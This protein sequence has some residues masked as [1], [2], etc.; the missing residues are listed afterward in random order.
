MSQW[1]DP[2]SVVVLSGDEDFLRVRE[3]R[4]AVAVSDETGRSV[5]YVEG[6]NRD[7]ISRVLSS[8]GVFFQ[9]DVLLVVERPEPVD[10][11]LLIRHHE[12]E[13]SS[14]CV[15]L[16][17]EGKIKPGTGLAEV[18]DA[19]P[20]RLVA[21]FDKP[22]PWEVVDRAVDFCVEQARRRE[23]KLPE[24][25]ARAIVQNVGADL[26]ML[27]FE[28]EKIARY[29]GSEGIAEATPGHVK[30]VLGAFSQLGPKPVVEALERRDSKQ[31]GNALAN[32]R[33]THAGNLS[34][35][36]LRACA[37][38][39][40]AA[41]GWLHVAA[42]LGEGADAEE[43]ASRVSAHPFVVRRNLL[44]VARRWGEGRLVSLL[45][46]IARVERSV[47]S[48]HVHPW[49]ELECALLGAVADGGSR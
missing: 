46:S 11:G 48:G 45:K 5:E 24:P 25:L 37:F 36:T 7:E 20:P 30:K 4:E 17:Q 14:V 39:S 43:I 31:T 27:T 21:K 49:V 29:L 22:K 26:G 2:P 8:T 38:V 35:A 33:R 10:P 34:G 44:P 23:V 9:E 42:L 3:L 28:V 13:S 6:V 41:I 18:A 40:R 12:S 16:H 32:M 1:R 15:V 19:L 47:R